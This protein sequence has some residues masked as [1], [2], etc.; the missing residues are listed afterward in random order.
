MPSTDEFEREM[1][2]TSRAGMLILLVALVAGIG[3][4]AWIVVHHGP[5]LAVVGTEWR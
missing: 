5:D 3:A 1:V 4:C 2:R